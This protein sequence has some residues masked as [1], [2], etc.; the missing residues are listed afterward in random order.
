M[1]KP[2]FVQKL[3]DDSIEQRTEE[4]YKRRTTMITASDCGVILGYNSKFTTT[5]D[6]LTGKLNN[7]RLDNV[8]LRHGNHY[9]PIAIDIFDQKRENLSDPFPFVAHLGA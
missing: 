7:I 2:Q 8:H 6:L 1:K 9:E 3:Q 4:W 5:E